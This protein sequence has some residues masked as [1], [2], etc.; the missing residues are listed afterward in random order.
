MVKEF[1][2]NVEGCSILWLDVKGENKGLKE[3]HFD[4]DALSMTILVDFSREIYVRIRIP[5]VVSDHG[6]RPSATIDEG[7]GM[8]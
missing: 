1:K 4:I 2:L 5:S 6:V 3:I 7:T 8:G